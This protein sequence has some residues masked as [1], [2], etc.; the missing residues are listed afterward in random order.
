MVFTKEDAYT[1]DAQMEAMSIQ[2]NIYYRA[3]VGSLIY[4]LSTIFY[5]CF[6]VHKLAKISSNP[7]KAHFDGLLHLLRYI[8]DNKNLVLRYYSKIYHAYLSYLLIQ[9]SINTENQLTM[10]SDSRWKDFT[11]NVTVSVSKSSD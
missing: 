9:S 10:F 4:L 3:C 1:S 7:G 11:D 6:A 5:L 8:R 2:Y